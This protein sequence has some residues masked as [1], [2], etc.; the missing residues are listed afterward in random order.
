MAISLRDLMILSEM[1]STSL[2]NMHC[3]KCLYVAT[4]GRNE[5]WPE[6]PDSDVSNSRHLCRELKRGYQY[7][8]NVYLNGRYP[9]S[10]FAMI[11]YYNIIANDDV[12]LFLWN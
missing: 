10:R 4:T 5:Q 8:T 6:V 11:L 3:T 9:H 2:P 1:M 12:E 7:L